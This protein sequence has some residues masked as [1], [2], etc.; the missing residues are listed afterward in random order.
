MVIGDLDK[1]YTKKEADTW[2][3]SSKD[4][5]I[6][7]QKSK[8]AS[9]AC[10]RFG[11]FLHHFDL[12][13]EAEQESLV[14]QF[15]G[16]GKNEKSKLPPGRARAKGHLMGATLSYTGS[17]EKVRGSDILSRQFYDEFD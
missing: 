8:R 16:P 14:A 12:E 4:E 17:G 6:R 2:T 9:L 7:A 13:D 15:G 10:V 3:G 11:E 1:E 5:A